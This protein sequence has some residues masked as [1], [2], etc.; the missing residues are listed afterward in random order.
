MT[1]K[2]INQKRMAGYDTEFRIVKQ[3]K[4]LFYE[5][6]LVKKITKFS[7]HVAFQKTIIPLNDLAYAEDYPDSDYV[8]KVVS[9]LIMKEREILSSMPKHEL[10]ANISLVSQ[11]Q[12]DLDNPEDAKQ[13]FF[14]EMSVGVVK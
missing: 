8:D 11:G 7:K 4:R 3:I 10:G 9:M 2:Q 12:I 1:F 14:I 13:L 6:S 5:K